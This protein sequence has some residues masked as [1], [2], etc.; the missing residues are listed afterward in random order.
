VRGEEELDMS[1][2]EE[3]EQE[4]ANDD[5]YL[6]RTPL[7]IKMYLHSLPVH[8]LHPPVACMMEVVTKGMVQR[9]RKLVSLSSAE[10][11]LHGCC[12]RF[13]SETVYNSFYQDVETTDRVRRIRYLRKTSVEQRLKLMT[14]QGLETHIWLGVCVFTFLFFC[15]FYLS[16]FMPRDQ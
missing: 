1:F 3:I 15:L 13:S 7:D 4:L 10:S 11:E 2:L 9:N 5:L 8:V 12:V 16:C 14:V 6:P